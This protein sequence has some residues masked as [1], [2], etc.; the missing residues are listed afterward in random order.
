[1][2]PGQGA[3]YVGCDLVYAQLATVDLRMADVKKLTRVL[4]RL[5]SGGHSPIPT[6]RAGR[7][8]RQLFGLSKSALADSEPQAAAPEGEGAGEAE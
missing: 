3:A 1:M 8:R 7:Q 4:H 6:S 2:P 5:V